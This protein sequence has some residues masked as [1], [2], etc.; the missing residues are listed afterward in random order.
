VNCHGPEHAPRWC[1]Q[2]RQLGTRLLLAALATIMLT[3]GCT[4][5][6]SSEDTVGST[7]T[8]A[9]VDEAAA[10]HPAPSPSSAPA[11]RV[12]HPAA[13][14][15][16]GGEGSTT[17]ATFGPGPRRRP[18]SLAPRPVR[19]AE[20]TPHPEPCTPAEGVATGPVETLVALQHRLAAT[21]LAAPPGWYAQVADARALVAWRLGELS[22]ADVPD[23]RATHVDPQALQA[24]ERWWARHCGTPAPTEAEEA[25]VAAGMD[26]DRARCVAPQLD[27]FPD[28]APTAL[29]AA[30]SRCH[31]DPETLSGTRALAVEG[32]GH[33]AQPTQ[34]RRR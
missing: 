24:V 26:L 6:P 29:A 31:V 21:S 3:A 33:V 17:V 25:L 34:P 32:A 13:A 27:T 2:V 12:P 5:G 28:V 11:R 15:P 1:R 14:S 19:D 10:G 8:E 20:P 30:L 18:P 23:Q 9:T 16:E 4:T 22:G 7:V